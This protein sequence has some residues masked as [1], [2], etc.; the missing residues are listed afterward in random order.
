MKKLL[1]FLVII[2]ATHVSFAQQT[3]K[4][5]DPAEWVNP[6]MG[7]ASNH[8][9]SNGNTYPAIA[10]PWGMNF[11]TP[12]TG[13]MGDGWQ[14]TYDATK[15][16]GFKQTHQPSPWMNDYGQFSVMPVTGH[17]AITQDKRASWFSHKTETAKPYYYSIYLAD[18]DVTAEITPTERS[19]QFRFTY[20]ENDSSSI[21]I[22][23][24]EKGSYVKIIPAENKIIGY[25]TQ[26]AHGLLKN[27]K[28]YFV[29]YA[30]KHFNIAHTYSDTA[31]NDGLELT[32]NH[33]LAVI[34]FKTVKGEQV[35]LRVASSFI[36]FE[37]AELNLKK[38]QGND[39]F[40]LTRQKAKAVWNKTLSHL[41][42][43]GGTVDQARTF[44][45]CLYRMLF[46]PN[47]LYEINAQNQPVHSG[48]C[49]ATG[50]A[51]CA[52]YHLSG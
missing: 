39:D 23:A 34:G 31:L 19:A 3:G 35:H 6:L 29:I 11:W 48:R 38:E 47:K 20:P 42:V 52:Q 21:V 7:T 1:V 25:S 5:D 12:Q 10:L 33:A 50:P 8:S 28:N 36:S 49:P 13:K 43:E 18:H 9:L 30:D 22:D 51:S 15:I 37:Q 32:A 26:H 24:F 16:L 46:F 17:T 27:F 4:I 45:S 41:A 2:A 44:Y 40:D 14:Y